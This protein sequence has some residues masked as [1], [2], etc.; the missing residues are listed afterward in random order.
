[1][2]RHIPRKRFGQNFL[3]DKSYIERII[4]SLNIPES[5]SIVEIGPGQ[6]ALTFPLL[7]QY[8]NLSVIELDRDLVAKL[9]EQGKQYGNLSIYNEDALK[10][11]FTK[12]NQKPLHVVGNLPYNIS[13]PILFHLFSHLDLIVSM[14]FMLQKEVVDRLAAEV[15]DSNYSRLSVMAQYYCEV[16]KLFD[17]PPGAFFPPPKVMSSVVSLHPKA[18]S[19]PPEITNLF[20]KVVKQAFSQRRKVLKTNLKQWLS[21]NDFEALELNPSSRAQELSV[22]DYIVITNYIHSH[23]STE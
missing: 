20:S 17:V 9:E 18:L 19:S 22:D 13:T 23:S 16:E 7:Q 5:E 21:T 3:H 4:N 15:N 12:L 2:N 6:G 8:E 11:D 1:M 10:F 14:T